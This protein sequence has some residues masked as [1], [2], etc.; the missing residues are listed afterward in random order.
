MIKRHM[1]GRQLRSPSP[2]DHA[3]LTSQ[4][5]ITEMWQR[6]CIYSPPATITK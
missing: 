3:R 5:I 2:P 1:Y 4:S 6:R